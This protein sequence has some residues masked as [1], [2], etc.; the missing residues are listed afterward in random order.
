M[1][2]Q[3]KHPFY[4]AVTVGE[5]GQIVIP[6]KAREDLGIKAGEKLLV[7]GGVLH[8]AGLLIFKSDQ[9]SSFLSRTVEYLSKLEKANP[10]PPEE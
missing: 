1:I 3:Q 5:R 2:D 6:Q 9:L 4:G 8:G 10:F 7:F